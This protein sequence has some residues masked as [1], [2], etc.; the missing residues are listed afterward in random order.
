MHGICHRKNAQK[1]GAKHFQALQEQWRNSGGESMKIIRNGK[2]VKVKELKPGDCFLTN[3][4][5]NVLLVTNEVISKLVTCVCPEDGSCISVHVD[6][7]VRKVDTV[8]TVE[9]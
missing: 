4:N 7:Y 9:G 6:E 1:L 2:Y 5:S 3:S 8:L